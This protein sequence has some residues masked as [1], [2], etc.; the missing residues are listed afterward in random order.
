MRISFAW[1]NTS[2]APVKDK[3]R[4]T[5]EAKQ[6]ALVVLSDLL[7]GKKISLLGLCELADREI[8]W[9]RLFCFDKGYRIVSGVSPI[10]KTNYDTCVIFREDIFEYEAFRNIS[11][12]WQ[13]N[14]QKIAQQIKLIIK[15]DG[16][17]LNVLVSHWP[18]V[19]LMN[20]GTPTRALFGD[21]LR[22]A[23]DEIWKVEPKSLIII[24]G[25]FNDEPFDE[26]LS[27][28]LQAT[29]DKELIAS[30][31]KRLYNPFW[32]RIGSNRDYAYTGKNDGFSGTYF[33]H[34]DKGDRWRTYDQIIFSSTFLGQSDWHLDE[35]SVSIVDIPPYTAQ[36]LNNKKKFDHL[37]V[38][39]TIEQVKK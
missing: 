7:L 20:K 32:S 26:P 5:E 9:L 17:S 36:V 23:V 28:N 31:A 10:G 11:D 27:F 12:V 3:G 39:A 16:R 37:P 8:E 4:A 1:W 25:D 33:Y 38:M 22:S 13:G 18:S 34:R 6:M 24:M 29:R 30:K 2:L 35:A 14:S 21:R 19:M 15:A